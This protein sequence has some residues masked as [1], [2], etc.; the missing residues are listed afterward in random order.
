VLTDDQAKNGVP[1]KQ[2]VELTTLNAPSDGYL[3][4]GPSHTVSIIAL[5]LCL[6]GT[7]A[8]TH[9]LAALRGGRQADG[10]AGII[11]PWRTSPSDERSAQP[12]P[13]SHPSP[14]PASVWSVGPVPHE[15]SPPAHRPAPA[16][17]PVAEKGRSMLGRRSPR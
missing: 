3:E 4:K 9:L 6:V 5:V 13:P 11:D 12:Q 17:A 2:R 1:P 10:I 16:P 8:F 15:P 7:L 14:E